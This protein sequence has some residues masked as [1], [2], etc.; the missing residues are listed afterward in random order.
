MGTEQ[1]N[2]DTVQHQYRQRF[3]GITDYRDAL[4]GV[5]CDDFFQSYI[6]RQ[7]A[8][9]DLGCGWGSSATIS[10]PARNTRWI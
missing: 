3:S 9:L 8:L 7:A 5:L 10:G 4:W 6:D 1:S 2:A